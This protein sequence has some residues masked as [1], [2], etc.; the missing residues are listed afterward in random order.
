M[1]INP[2]VTKRFAEAMQTRTETNAVEAHVH[3]P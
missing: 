2:K 3:Q 1:V